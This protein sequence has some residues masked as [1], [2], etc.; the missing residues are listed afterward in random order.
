MG[1]RHKIADL[2]PTAPTELMEHESHKTIEKA[3]LRRYGKRLPSARRRRPHRSYH[4]CTSSQSI[5][6][7]S[8]VIAEPPGAA[9]L[10]RFKGATR[11]HP[12]C[13]PVTPLFDGRA[14]GGSHATTRTASTAADSA[15]EDVGVA[16]LEGA[17]RPFG[18]RSASARPPRQRTVCRRPR[19]RL[20]WRMRLLASGRC[21]GRSQA[22]GESRRGASS[23]S[24]GVRREVGGGGRLSARWYVPRNPVGFTIRIFS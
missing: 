2:L 21:A 20:G 16:A 15:S 18:R 5:R 23:E 6:H 8:A 9:A 22:M 17:R 14:C 1:G 4:G 13:L 12:C 11:P 7:P 24:E 19:R 10:T 3:I